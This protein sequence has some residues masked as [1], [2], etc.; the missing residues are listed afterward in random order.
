MKKLGSQIMVAVVCCILG[1]MLA[2]Q[3]KT[4]TKYGPKIDVNKGT[5]D[6]TADVE[7]YKKDKVDMQKS[8]DELQAQVDKYEKAAT[9]NNEISKEILSELE[10][11]RLLTGAYDVTGPGITVRLT[12]SSTIFGTTVPNEKVTY[13]HLTFLVNELRFAGA[14][15]IAIN[16]YRITARTGIKSGRDNNYIIINGVDQKVSPMDTIEVTAI[17]NVDLLKKDL[18][19]KGTLDDF[20]NISDIKIIESD[21][22]KIPKSTKISKFEYAMP[23]K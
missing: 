6:I 3:F 2:Y 19:F 15:A 16:G 12:P 14:E 1:F 5:T 20:K 9:N 18:N 7:Q 11:L 8:V 21:K 13:Q 10:N 4:L 23:T 22:I 17:G